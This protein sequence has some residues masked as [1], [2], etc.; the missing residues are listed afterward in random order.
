MFGGGGGA[1]RPKVRVRGVFGGG[2]GAWRPKVRVR[3]VFGGG[4]GAWRPK[5]RVR[6]VFGGGGGAWRPPKVSHRILPYS[7]CDVGIHHVLRVKTKIYNV[8][9][10]NLTDL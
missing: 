4:G 8:M 3:G 10:T 7:H 2:G 5:V 6:G 1:W 9:S